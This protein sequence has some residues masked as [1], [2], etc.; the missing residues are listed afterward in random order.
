MKKTHSIY[1]YLIAIQM[2]LLLYQQNVN[3]Q[4]IVTADMVPSD[5]VEAVLLGEGVIVSN[6]TYQG[7]MNQFARFTTGANPTNLGISSGIILT[8]GSVNSPQI[9]SPA[10][11]FASSQT[12]HGGHPLL[13]GIVGAQTFDAAVLRFDFV[14]LADIIEFNYVFASEEYHVYVNSQFNDV[15]G[16]FISGANPQGG[17]YVNK[18]IALIP[19]TNNPVTINN[20]NNGQTSG[21]C[22]NGP[23]MNC[24]FF[25]DNKCGGT[26][27]V[28]DGF[29]TVLTARAEVVPCQQYTII[30]AVAD[31]NDRVFDSAVFLEANSF[32]TSA[33]TVDVEYQLPNINDEF[34]IEDCSNANLVFSIPQ[35]ML[36]DLTINFSIAGSATNCVDYVVLPD[37]VC[38]PQSIIIP[39]GQ[40]SAMLELYAFEDNITEG[41][42]TIEIIFS[43]ACNEPDTIFINI[44]D[45]KPP[46]INSYNSNICNIPPLQQQINMPVSDGNPPF[47][48]QWSGGLGSSQNPIV[49]LSGNAN[50]TVT[51]TDFCNNTATAQVTFNFYNPL[52]ISA[53]AQPQTICSGEGVVLTASGADS[54]NWIGFVSNQ[55]PVTAYPES[56]TTYTV[57]GTDNASGCTAETNVLVNVVPGINVVINTVSNDICYGDL[58][59]LNASGADNYIWST[60]SEQVSITVSPTATTTYTVTGTSSGCSGTAEITINVSNP[61]VTISPE[62]TNICQGD[63]I[64]LEASGSTSYIWSNGVN[65]NINIVS[66]SQTTTYS[67]IGTDSNNCTATNTITVEVNPLPNISILAESTEIC[68]GQ[69]LVLTGSGADTY[70]W[71][72]LDT[73]TNPISIYPD[74]TMQYSVIGTS[75]AGCSASDSILI[76]VLPAP[77][78]NFSADTTSGCLPLTVQFTDIS[79]GGNIVSWYWNFGDGNYS[80]LQNPTH[81]FTLSGTY[82]VQLVVTTDKG[83]KDTLVFNNY[84]EVYPQPIADFY[85]TPEIGKTYNPTI[86]F[87]SNAETQYWNWNF[88][89]GN[90]SNFPPPVQ[91]TYPDKDTSYT[92]TLIVS[93]DYGCFD[94]ITKEILIIDDI[95]IFPN[96]FTPNGDGF[97]DFL[98]IQ[99]GEKY[100]NNKIIVFNRWGKKVFEQTNYQNDWDGSNLADGTY[101]Y[102]FYYLDKSYQS[103][104]TILR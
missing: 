1:L 101:Y 18:N 80:T 52:V 8:T 36:S 98:V 61:I 25:V 68:Y 27:I 31:V 82:D 50:Y 17:S 67:V 78:G 66:P 53:T 97:N 13:T 85:T 57:I 84:V 39:A 100:D 70:Y 104:L 35:P 38:L 72:E 3:G 92:V 83:C 93:N 23:C 40:T 56:T 54:F 20:V 10:N 43:N 9:G 45:N 73:N 21:A 24:Q 11:I 33:F 41:V 51:V 7:A 60:G 48:Y 103:S 34:M 88:G 90:T 62:N 58:A 16:F 86:T 46:T 44:R 89:D 96:I 19:G 47:T 79:T 76:T 15:F 65:N 2:T 32:G 63:T 71:I 22:T 28:Y 94:T 14:P 37:S 87:Y 42:E 4:L 49:N 59:I 91:N 74:S 30:I 5:Y 6:I 75:N 55:N 99:N 77:F 12:G 26:S 81:I 64:T 95:L 29:T 69:S 102:I